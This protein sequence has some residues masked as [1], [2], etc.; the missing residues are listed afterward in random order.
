M[1]RAA[2]APLDA[3]EID[4]FRASARRF[5][6][7]E[8]APHVAAW[9]EAETFPRELYA[10]GR[11]GRPASASAIPRRYGG[12]PAPMRLRLVATEEVARAGSGGL[13]AS[14][15]SHSIGLPPIVAHGSEALQAP[16]RAADVLAGG[17]IAALRHHRARRRLRRR[18][19]AHHAPA[20][21]ATTG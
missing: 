1:S 6:E 16:H 5:V 19:P 13:M 15:F 18:R 21:T 9:D 3:A 12:T 11:R 7:R 2:A 8:I 17:K 14:L 4:A 20:A 10:Q